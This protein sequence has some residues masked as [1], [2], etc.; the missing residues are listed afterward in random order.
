[1]S[2]ATLLLA[3]L[4]F[5]AGAGTTNGTTELATGSHTKAASIYSPTPNGTTGGGPYAHVP[6]TSSPVPDGFT[7]GGPY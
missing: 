4:P 6:P 7:G 5:I 1:M 2:I 3:L